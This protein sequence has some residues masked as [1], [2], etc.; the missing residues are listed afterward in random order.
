MPDASLA[1]LGRPLPT[2]PTAADIALALVMASRGMGE[3]LDL[4]GYALALSGATPCRSKWAAMAALRAVWGGRAARGVAFRWRGGESH[5]EKA[6]ARAKAAKWWDERLVGE[7]ART[8]INRY[9][10]PSRRVKPC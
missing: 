9:H 6:F 8:L 2:L 4:A 7:I 5:L 10:Y 1:I 3:G